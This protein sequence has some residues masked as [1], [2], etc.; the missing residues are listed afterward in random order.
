MSK[1]STLDPAYVFPAK[2]F[3]NIFSESVRSAS[4]IS[5]EG[6]RMASISKTFATKAHLWASQGVKEDDRTVFSLMMGA[7]VSGKPPNSPE[8]K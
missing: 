7:A 4:K 2:R 3:V 1:F 6:D 5:S 8:A